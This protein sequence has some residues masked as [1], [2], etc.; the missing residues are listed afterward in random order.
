MFSQALAY[1]LTVFGVALFPLS[2]YLNIGLGRIT[3]AECLIF[4]AIVLA[5]SGNIRLLR[6]HKLL[7][8]PL[9]IGIFMILAGA[10]GD[11]FQLSL[12]Q[13]LSFILYTVVCPILISIANTHT[14]LITRIFV[15]YA[16]VNGFITI[17][18]VLIGDSP[19]AWDTGNGRVATVLSGVGGGALF[20]AAGMAFFLARYSLN[21]KKAQSILFCCLLF[22]GILLDS[23]VTSLV[24]ALSLLVV[25]FA[26]SAGRRNIFNLLFILAL[27]IGV[28]YVLASVAIIKY[29]SLDTLEFVGDINRR[30][31]F[32]T[33]LEA[34]MTG[35]LLGFGL[36]SIL[37]GP[38]NEPIHNAYLQLAVDI[39]PV[40]A[41]L[42]FTYVV[43]LGHNL[44]KKTNTGLSVTSILGYKISFLFVLILGLHRLFHPLGLVGTDWILLIIA[45][46]HYSDHP[47]LKRRR[48]LP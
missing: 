19:L 18:H 43:I 11:N 37:A 7:L 5:V 47:S 41:L 36:E 33:A 40:A 10:R 26:S 32:Y 34:L 45:W 20:S 17:T 8:M 16:L 2:A 29:T 9:G 42:F 44:L 1:R 46:A 28:G 38:T 31:Q 3:I 6:I 24:I 4:S 13:S 15:G 27:L 25:T 12:F 30:E 35:Q 48:N 14:T 22:F 39:S 23:S 21:I